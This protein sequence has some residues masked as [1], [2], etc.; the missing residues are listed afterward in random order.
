MTVPQSDIPTYV[1]INSDDR[2][3]INRNYP[4][5]KLISL[6]LP[7]AALYNTLIIYPKVSKEGIS[8]EFCSG[9]S[10]H[11]L[12]KHQPWQKQ[13]RTPLWSL[14]TAAMAFNNNTRSQ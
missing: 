5:L 3:G 6:L 14:S 13:T 8:M 7:C 10:F 1:G 9:G 11:G 2:V 4:I 12:G